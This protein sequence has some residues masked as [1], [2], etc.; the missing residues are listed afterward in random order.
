MLLEHVYIGQLRLYT[1]CGAFVRDENN[2]H[3]LTMMA[4]IGVIVVSV[5]IYS[6]VLP[7][8]VDSRHQTLSSECWLV[9]VGA[10]CDARCGHLP[11]KT[12]SSWI[13]WGFRAQ[14][15]AALGRC[16]DANMMYMI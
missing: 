5:V 4:M 3:Y 16:R 2:S 1:E 14:G 11:R 7:R 13:G 12:P 9:L 10:S 8:H 6:A 15:D